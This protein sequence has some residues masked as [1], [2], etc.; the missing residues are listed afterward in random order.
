MADQPGDK[1]EAVPSYDWMPRESAVGLPE[2]TRKQGSTGQWWEVRSGQWMRSNG[3][4]GGASS[5]SGN[6]G[7]GN[8]TFATG[9]GGGSWPPPP[10]TSAIT[11]QEQGVRAAGPDLEKMRAGG[12]AI[13]ERDG[14]MPPVSAPVVVLEKVVSIFAAEDG[15]FIRLA[16]ETATQGVVGLQI[17]LTTVSNLIASLRAGRYA[18]EMAIAR[19]GETV[20]HSV[21]MV[22]TFAC[23]DLEGVP[24]LLVTLNVDTPQ[25]TMICLPELQF[26]REFAK[27]VAGAVQAA[28]KKTIAV[29]RAQLLDARGKPVTPMTRKN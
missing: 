8:S 27:A 21:E 25:E 24:G 29:P 14:P 11:S 19:A 22:D 3:A 6:N 18:A 23:G 28:E 26:A 17:E 10:Q 2:G 1:S 16:V 15:K 13:I 7:G 9:G 20:P 12:D 4:A 5:A